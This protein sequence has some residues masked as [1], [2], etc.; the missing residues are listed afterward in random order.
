MSKR[1]EVDG[2][3]GEQGLHLHLGPTS[4]LRFSHAVLLFGIGVDALANRASAFQEM[5]SVTAAKAVLHPL[6]DVGIPASRDHTVGRT[7]SALWL[8][9]ALSTST[10]GDFVHGL[11]TVVVLADA[12]QLLAVGADVEIVLCDVRE[13]RAVK[14]T[15]WIRVRP[16]S[17]QRLHVSRRLA[18]PA[19]PP[20]VHRGRSD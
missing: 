20:S 9:R 7:G 6:N 16:H 8:E 3:G 13:F 19:A 10:L 18:C 11:V 2:G 4:E 14:T 1:L 17:E 15:M 12:A 5:P